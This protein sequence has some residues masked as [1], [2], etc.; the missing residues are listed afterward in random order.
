MKRSPATALWLSMLPGAGHVY[1]GQA[2]KGFLLI[3]LFAC[4]IQLAD[5]AAFFGVMI[6]FIWLFGLIDAYRSAQEHNL[7]VETGRPLPKPAA[8]A[9]TR[10]WGWGLIGLGTVFFVDNF[11]WLDIEWIWRIWPLGLIGLGVYILKQPNVPQSDITAESPPPIPAT[12]DPET[13]DEREDASEE[14]GQAEDM[15]TERAEPTEPD[16]DAESSES[17][18]EPR[19]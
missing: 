6:P 17:Q 12:P 9:F 19:A 15:P 2:S 5:H 8:F 1:V 10:W 14:S 3:V 7:L 16:A 18:S 13:S 4:A 11:G